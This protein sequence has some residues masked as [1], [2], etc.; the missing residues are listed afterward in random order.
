M[1]ANLSN[2][3][4]FGKYKLIG[5]ITSATIWVR[6]DGKIIES[7]SM[8]EF[9]DVE[10]DGNDTVLTSGALPAGF[11]CVIETELNSKV[12]SA[13][14]RLQEIVEEKIVFDHKL[15]VFDISTLMFSCSK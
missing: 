8:K 11:S 2:W 1:I 10:S 3:A 9:F 7:S 5:S 12:V 4:E 13:I 15:S 6:T 14:E